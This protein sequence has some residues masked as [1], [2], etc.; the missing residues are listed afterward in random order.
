MYIC[1]VDSDKRLEDDPLVSIDDDDK[2]FT[3]NECAHLCALL[4]DLHLQVCVCV[5]VYVC[6]LV[7]VLVC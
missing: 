7:C 5:C 3:L 1:Q 2:K 4:N 6:V